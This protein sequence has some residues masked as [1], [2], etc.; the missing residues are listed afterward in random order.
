M[1]T[2]LL[3]LTTL[4]S[5]SIF[6]SWCTNNISNNTNSDINNENNSSWEIVWMAN[7]ASIHCEENWWT[8][9]LV[10]DNGESYGMCHFEN[11]AVCEEREFFRKECFP[12][13]ENGEE[14]HNIINNEDTNI[15]DTE[16]QKEDIE[17]E[18]ENNPVACT[19]DAKQCPD[20]TYVWRIWPDCEFK[21]CP[22]QEDE[23]K[24]NNNT[25]DEETM[26]DILENHAN[27]T[28]YQEEWLTQA[29]I[30]LMEAIIEKL[31]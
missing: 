6:A 11:W 18:S 30:D 25:Q 19:M 13:T 22:T 2:K 29:D 4:L 23:N 15:E 16:N 10:F 12:M 26:T 31:K 28:Q 7:P 27:T 24:T 14:I 3:I 8:L 1:K 20:G 21:I 5:I 9:E 17:E